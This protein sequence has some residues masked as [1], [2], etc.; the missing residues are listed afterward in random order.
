MGTP[1]TPQNLLTLQPTLKYRSL[2]AGPPPTQSRVHLIQSSGEN[3]LTLIFHIFLPASFSWKSILFFLT[4]VWIPGCQIELLIAK[5]LYFGPTFPYRTS[6][7]EFPFWITDLYTTFFKIGF[8]GSWVGQWG[9]HPTLDLDSG[10]DLKVIRSSPN[11][12]AVSASTLGVGL[13]L[14]SLS[15]LLPLPLSCHC[16]HV[17]F[18]SQNTQTKGY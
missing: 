10:H 4:L 18:L 16:T 8:W 5:M 14:V 15:P 1:R 17:F 12:G 2:G 9:K 13:A 7:P 6:G 3:F 11:L